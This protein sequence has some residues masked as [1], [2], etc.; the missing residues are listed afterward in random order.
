MQCLKSR[1][2]REKLN[3]YKTPLG[4]F[5]PKSCVTFLSFT[6]FSEWFALFFSGLAPPQMIPGAQAVPGDAA[7]LILHG[8]MPG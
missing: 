2:Q 6:V 1:P 8:L 3:F 5:S 7:I 4:S